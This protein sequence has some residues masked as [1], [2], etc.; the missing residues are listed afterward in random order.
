MNKKILLGMLVLVLAFGMT[1]LGC[2]E[3]LD[4]PYT[5]T[6]PT[7]DP[8][9]GTVT[10]TSEI[11]YDEYS[12]EIMT[13][14][15]N[16]SA[17]NNKSYQKLSYEWERD[18]TNISGA[19][20]ETYVV[21]DADI[22]KTLKVKVT[23][24]S[25]SGEQYGEF[26]VPNKTTMTVSVKFKSSTAASS[27]VKDVYILIFH[28]EEAI[29][30]DSGEAKLI[31]NLGTT[32]ETVTLASWTATKFKIFLNY[33]DFLGLTRYCFKKMGTSDEDFNLTDKTTKSYTLEY[34][35]EYGYKNLYATEE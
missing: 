22:G 31:T 26:D 19:I 9:T 32:A 8:L 13:L 16:T 5:I 7:R 33:R 12:K 4:D 3:E 18:G 20:D 10:V 27:G 23:C 29:S 21:T 35:Y 14:T 25:L 11:T 2:R 1:V 24:S 30:W 15:A 28:K 34:L 17:L 6:S